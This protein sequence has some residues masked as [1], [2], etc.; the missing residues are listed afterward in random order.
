MRLITPLH[1]ILF[2]RLGWTEDRL[3][4]IDRPAAAVLQ[5]LPDV[6]GALARARR[7][8]IP[9]VVM[10]DFD[11]D[12]LTSGLIAF[13]GLAELGLSVHLDFGDYRWGHDITPARAR[14]LD[15]T[16][17][18]HRGIVLTTDAGVNSADGIEALVN[19]GWQVVVTDHHQEDGVRT[20]AG[21]TARDLALAVVDPCGI[22]ETY[23][24]PA[25]CGAQVAFKVVIALAEALGADPWAVGRLRPLAAVGAISDVMPLLHESRVLVRDGLVDLAVLGAAGSPVMAGLRAARAHPLLTQVLTGFAELAEFAAKGCGPLDS[26]GVAFSLAP[27]LNAVR[28][29]EACPAALPWQAVLH[30]DPQARQQFRVLLDENNTAR[31]ERSGAV[32][33]A[34]LKAADQPLAPYVYLVDEVPGML[35]LIAGALAERQVGPVAV[36]RRTGGGGLA[37]S[38]RAGVAGVDLLAIAAGLDGVRAAG[39]AQACGVFAGCEAAAAALAEGLGAAHLAAQAGRPSPD[40]AWSAGLVFGDHPLADAARPGDGQLLDLV[41]MIEP[42]G[43]FGHGWPRPVHLAR[44]RRADIRLMSMSDGKHTRITLPWGLGLVWWNSA[45]ERDDLAA[46]PP[47]AEID[48]AFELAKNTFRDQTKPQGVVRSAAPRDPA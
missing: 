6:V 12:G 5:G 46:L 15:E 25:I 7:D 33:A 1:S 24:D 44:S 32:V 29:T 35:G 13:A 17:R 18:D 38:G 28:R 22:G 41:D 39:H 21:L 20:A 34:L 31:K 2:E 11:A 26:A 48:F 45:F 42:R 3:A 27:M 37:G 8:G 40:Q 14:H 23:P 47:G 36:L 4:E 9:V 10:P 19:L 30:P 16:H 43:P